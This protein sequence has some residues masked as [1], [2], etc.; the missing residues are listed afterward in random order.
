MGGFWLGRGGFRWSIG[1]RGRWGRFGRYRGTWRLGG[2]FG[3][4]S[5]WVGVGAWWCELLFVVIVNLGFEF[6]F[7]LLYIDYY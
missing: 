2:W 7:V 4:R 1:R 3:G 5:R 6:T